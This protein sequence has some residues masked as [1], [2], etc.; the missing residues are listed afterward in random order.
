MQPQNSPSPSPQYD[1][2]LNDQKQPAKSKWGFLKNL[3]KPALMLVALSALL[4]V[5]LVV[6]A[7]SQG[8]NQTQPLISAAA[9][10]QEISRISKLAGAQTKDPATMALAATAGSVLGS[11][12]SQL[13]D[14]LKATG[15][16]VSSAD[17]LAYQDKNT[18]GQ[19]TKAAQENKLEQTYASFLKENLTKYK[20]DL[21][22]ASKSAGK[23]G[24]TL[25]DASL[26]STDTLLSA[27]QLIGA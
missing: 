19:L 26:K 24:Q 21:Q 27:P 5:I 9:R 8:S 11:E 15:T 18:D 6:A 14:Y 4:I 16:D 10:A 2:I 20:T 1:F 17:L 7:L 23:N 25:I 13:S 22:N 12:Q 3:P